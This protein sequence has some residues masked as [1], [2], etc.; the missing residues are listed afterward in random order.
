MLGDTPCTIKRKDG[1]T[2][3]LS[4]TGKSI[5]PIQIDPVSLSEAALINA[6]SPLDVFA[7]AIE[8]ISIDVHAGD[9]V[10][11]ASGKLDPDTGAAPVYTVA[12]PPLGIPNLLYQEFK[13]I[14]FRGD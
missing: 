7:G 9:Q 13:M 4:S 10:T 11:D 14:R 6:K 3:V 8:G 12:G 2:P 1:T 5:I